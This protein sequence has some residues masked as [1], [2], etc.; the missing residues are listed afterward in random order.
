[1]DIDDPAW[2]AYRDA[3]AR[4]APFKDFVVERNRVIGGRWYIRSSGVPIFDQNGAFRGYRGV[5]SDV[6]TAQRAM[7]ELRNAEA[8]LR[9]LRGM[10]RRS[11]DAL[12]KGEAASLISW[13]KGFA[14][15]QA[16]DRAS[17]LRYQ[18]MVEHLEAANVEL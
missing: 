16:C 10:G 14:S 13:K 5:S 18:P 9:V 1:M 8:Q 17:A 2:R 6:T 7:V 4:R 12:T 11:K 15:V 3:V